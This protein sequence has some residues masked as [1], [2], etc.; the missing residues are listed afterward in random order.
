MRQRY[1]CFESEVGVES[2]GRLNEL[3]GGALWD[4]S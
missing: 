2:G 1:R 3:R 4:R